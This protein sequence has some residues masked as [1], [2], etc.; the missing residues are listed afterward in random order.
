MQR[1][2]LIESKRTH[3]FVS[4]A[5]A[6]GEREGGAWP[7][8]GVLNTRRRSIFV[9]R[10]ERQEQRVWRSAKTRGERP[11]G[12]GTRG[13][14]RRQKKPKSYKT[15]KPLVPLWLGSGGKRGKGNDN[16]EKR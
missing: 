10:N 14:G 13:R 8:R 1:K 16:D 5:I 2:S 11:V 6:R 4:G 7:S 3:P 9:K 12:K 15:K